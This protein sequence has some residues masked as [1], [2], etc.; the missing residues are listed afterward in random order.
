MFIPTYRWY[1]VGGAAALLALVAACR[2]DNMAPQ[3]QVPA[4]SRVQAESLGQVMVAEAQSELDGITLSGAGLGPALAAPV[5]PL[6]D[7]GLHC[8][9]DRS[10][11][12]VVNSDGDRVP[13]S[14]RIT[15]PNCAF[16]EGD[17]ADTISGSID[18][19]DPTPT[20]TDR[21][22]KMVF[23][24]FRRVE[25]EHGRTRSTLVNGARESLRDVNEISQSETDFRT[26]FVFRDGDTATSAR[27]WSATFTADVPGAI[28]PDAALPSGTVNIAG[29][30]TFTRDT[31]SFALTVSTDPVLHYN[32]ACTVRPKFDAGTLKATVTKNGATSNVT[33]AFTAC[34]T[35]TVTRS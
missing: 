22:R 29:T 32:A 11:A 23:T 25:V 17:E 33:I 30:A 24:D 26:V 1:F 19:I 8:I 34:G 4:L 5:G 21:A 10:P 31:N 15:F 16:T 14:V 12:P 7:E 13:D 27:N 28:Q 3:N 6:A 2:T 20:V 9:P 18:I 35:F